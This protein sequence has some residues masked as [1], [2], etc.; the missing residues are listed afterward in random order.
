MFW[1]GGKKV[2]RKA[3]GFSRIAG[4]L[5]KLRQEKE[6]AILTLDCGDTFHG[7]YPAVHT[8]GEVML[9]VLNA[10]G[11]DAMTAHWEFA[12]GP[13]QFRKLTAALNYPMLAI[14]IYDKQTDELVYNPYI[15]KE[16]NGLKVG[17]I[18]IACNIVDKTMPPHFS[19]GLYFTLG[20]D[21]LPGYIKKLKKEENADLIVLI[22]HLGFP[23]N[24]KLL[25][26]VPGVDVCL[27]SHTHYRTQQP[28]MQGNTIVI[29]SGCHGS[30]LGRLDLTVKD[31]K[32][33]DFTHEMVE[34]S[35]DLPADAAVEKLVQEATAPFQEK[36]QQEVGQVTTHLDRN[37]ILEATMDNFLLQSMISATGAELA[38]SNGWRYGAP[39]VPGPVTLNDLYNI[40][41]MNPPVQTAE[42]TGQEL[43]QMLEENLERTFAPDAYNQLGGYVKRCL[44]LKAFIKIEA[45]KG[46]RIQKLFV[47]DEEVILS[48]NYKA[49]F[50][51]EQ[52]ISKKYGTNR[53][54]SGIKAIDAMLQFLNNNSP[55]EVNLR[56]TFE[57]V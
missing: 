7:T 37:N 54:E 57:A 39:I 56:G 50:V 9:P 14:N 51:T 36:L 2:Y 15:L 8:K 55:V 33:T 3:G 21:E 5:N 23:Q 35:D 43:W 31:G 26:E 44:G 25:S 40:I 42:I 18:G 11:L 13:E 53:Q 24:M 16:V 1:E 27:S 22:S 34:V 30:F 38:F 4:Y 32:I 20:N 47:D 49:A 46:T 45:P 12:Y 17:V 28:I 19:K 52:G 6:G 48:K 10:L 41:P 29:E